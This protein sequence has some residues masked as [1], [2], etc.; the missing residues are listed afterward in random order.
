MT[1]ST[2]RSVDLLCKNIY[3]SYHYSLYE[4]YLEMATTQCQREKTRDVRILLSKV[5]NMHLRTDLSYIKYI[6]L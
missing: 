1:N 6:H 5:P 2:S 3:H 4:A